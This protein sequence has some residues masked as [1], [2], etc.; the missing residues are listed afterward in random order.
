MKEARMCLKHEHN[1]K[2][3]NSAFKYCY[4][5]GSELATAITKEDMRV[6]REYLQDPP[7]TKDYELREITT[8]WGHWMGATN[9]FKDKKWRWINNSGTT[10][11]LNSGK[12]YWDFNEPLGVNKC[13]VAFA[14][15]FTTR[16]WH[17][18][19]AHDCY[20]KRPFVCLIR[21]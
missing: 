3:W 1:L 11:S 13:L 9:R 6:L 19:N 18:W 20:E 2:N 7:F 10:V 4:D 8:F 15:R 5:M 14:G 12:Q 21:Y 17:G 16:D